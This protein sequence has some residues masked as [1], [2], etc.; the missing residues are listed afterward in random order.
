M[1][2]TGGK[3]TTQHNGSRN[4]GTGYSGSG[5]PSKM[6]TSAR[7]GRSTSNYYGGSDYGYSSGECGGSFSGGCSFS[8]GDCGGGD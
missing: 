4:Y 7:S 5:N 2:C 3:M 6:K 8:G 1:G